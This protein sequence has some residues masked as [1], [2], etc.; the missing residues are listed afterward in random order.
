MNENTST[1]KEQVRVKLFDQDRAA[2]GTALAQLLQEI[3]T[4]EEQKKAHSK[5]CSSRIEVLSAQVS[6]LQRTINQGYSLNETECIWLM[7]TP[8]PGL[9]TLVRCDNNEEVRTENMTDTDAQLGLDMQPPS[10][11]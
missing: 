9:K 1:I 3:E 8:R 6:N 4:V 10:G 11:D 5:E 7:S 2:M